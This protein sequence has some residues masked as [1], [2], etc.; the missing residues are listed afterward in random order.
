MHPLR[1]LECTPWIVTGKQ[2]QPTERN[3]AIGKLREVFTELTGIQEPTR[4]SDKKFWYGSLGEIYNITDKNIDLAEKLL[5]YS[6]DR[7]ARD[8]LTIS[9]PNSLVKTARSV[10]AERARQRNID[11]AAKEH[12]GALVL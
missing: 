7:L 8:D 1:V 3:L 2:R 10:W 6:Y 11:L 12:T 5:R 4:K 9:D